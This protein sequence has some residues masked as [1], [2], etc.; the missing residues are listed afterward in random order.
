[1]ASKPIRTARLAELTNASRTRAISSNVA[2]RGTCQFGPNGI[3]DGPIVSQGSAPGGS[4]PPPSQGRCAD[5]LRPA[6][7]SWMPSLG[8]GPLAMG[9][10]PRHGRL[11]V[12]GIKPG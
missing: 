10:D 4:G 3:G 5:A 7:A 9:D 8:A 12:V 11:V 2:T 6:C 1:M